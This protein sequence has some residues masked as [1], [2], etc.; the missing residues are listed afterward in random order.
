MPVAAGETKSFKACSFEEEEAEEGKEVMKPLSNEDVA[1][2]TELRNN[3]DNLEALANDLD[4][5][6]NRAGV[7]A[8]VIRTILRRAHSARQRAVQP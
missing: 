5:V 2:L 6:V 8:A 7:A 4:D 3:Y 1:E